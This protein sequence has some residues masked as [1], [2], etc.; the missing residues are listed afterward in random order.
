MSQANENKI[1][2][3]CGSQYSYLERKRVYGR[4]YVYA[5]HEYREGGK[6]HRKWCCLGPL[7]GYR[8]ATTTH[9]VYGLFLKS[10][11]DS[12]RLYEYLD[13][14]VS[15]LLEDPSNIVSKLGVDRSRAISLATKLDRLS[16]AILGS[17]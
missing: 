6:R 9:E 16:K 10:A 2:P 15:Y 13:T 8:H 4:V 7:E 12:N 5:V 14:I 17:V 3:R 1:C 11:I